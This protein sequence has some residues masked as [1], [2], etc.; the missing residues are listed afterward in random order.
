MFHSGATRAGQVAGKVADSTACDDWAVRTT[1]GPARS[2]EPDD[3]D[4]GV[5]P[6]A[7]C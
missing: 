5:A 3:R 7:R 4:D 1:S 2:R 6:A